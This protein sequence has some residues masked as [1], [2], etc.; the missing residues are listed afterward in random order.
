[1]A[2]IAAGL[3]LA[4]AF[5]SSPATAT[6]FKFNV[7]EILDEFPEFSVFN[8]LLSRTRLVDEVNLRPA[9]TVLVV[10]DDAAS[11]ITSLPTATQGEVL[12]LQVLLDYYDPVKL[13]G[14]KAKTALLPT[15]LRP[16]AAGAGG[17]GLVRYIQVADDQ[18]VF[19]S[20]EPGAP[21]GS[22]LVRVVASRPY[23]LSVMQVSAP[24]VAPSIGGP[25]SG[26][27]R[28]NGTPPSSPATAKST[29]ASDEAAMSDY[30]DDPIAP[31]ATVD[32]PSAA[33]DGPANVDTPPPTTS[34]SNKT[35]TTTSAG[36]R[37]MVGAGVRLIAGFLMLISIIFNVN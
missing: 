25:S 31:S 7:T 5:A 6:A 12:A 24:I 27:G 11:A 36:R 35:T 23:N 19:G 2:A 14:I 30:D 21:V 15:L 33:A 17:V 22:Q 1:M 26:E 20:G 3:I 16:T 18:M 28:S 34:S 37:V 8:G 32:T 13:D 10:D 9:V 4:L 29:E